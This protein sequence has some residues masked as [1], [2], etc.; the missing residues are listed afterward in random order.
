MISG[1]NEPDAVSPNLLGMTKAQ[2]LD[3][4]DQNGVDGV[5]SRMNKADIIS[6]IEG[7]IE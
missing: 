4:A 5:S 1:Q 6:T 2:L 3:Y 7:A